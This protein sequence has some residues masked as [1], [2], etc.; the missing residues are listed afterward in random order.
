MKAVK[1]M[2][3]NSK[4]DAVAICPEAGK[5]LKTVNARQSENFLEFVKI[6]FSDRLKLHL[7]PDGWPVVEVGSLS[8]E[9][10]RRTR[11]VHSQTHRHS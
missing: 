7:D 5:G 10:M 8:G 2:V 11:P 1:E 9:H 3:T 6:P 4:R